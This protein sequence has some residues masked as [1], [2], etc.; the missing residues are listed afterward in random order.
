[1]ANIQSS[2]ADRRKRDLCLLALGDHNKHQTQ[3]SVLILILIHSVGFRWRRYSRLVR[4]Y[5][6]RRTTDA[7]DKPEESPIVI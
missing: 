3:F 7:I 5:R 6:Y 1:M 4:I 2:G